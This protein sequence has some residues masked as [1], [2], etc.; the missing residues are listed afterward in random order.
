MVTIGACAAL[1][2]ANRDVHDKYFP[3]AVGLLG[4]L[5]LLLV[6]SWLLSVALAPQ[7]CEWS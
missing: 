3:V 4:R 2:A 5:I 6:P 1:A 7:L